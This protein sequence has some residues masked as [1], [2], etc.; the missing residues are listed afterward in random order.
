MLEFEAFIGD[1]SAS[2]GEAS[3]NGS[4]PSLNSIMVE[5]EGSRGVPATA[6]KFIELQ[7]E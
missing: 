2:F 4:P 3:E 6:L 7:S 1:L 5:P